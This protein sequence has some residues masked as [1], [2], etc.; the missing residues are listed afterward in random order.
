MESRSTL[1]RDANR[2]L[3]RQEYTRGE[4]VLRSKPRAL[5]IELTRHCN[6]AC[7]MCRNPGEVPAT[8]R[9]TEQLF[10]R[11]ERE[12]F[13]TADLI[14][15]RGW[16][17]S[18]IL[19]EFEDRAVRASAFGASLRV[20]TNLSFRR[21]RILDLLAELG[22][23]VGVS[24]DSADAEVLALL[25]RGA[26]L[27]LIERNLRSLADAYHRRGAAARLN[28]YVTCQKPALPTLERIV[29]LA[30]RAGIGD[31]RFAP[32]GTRLPFLSIASESRALNDAL[33]RVRV[34]AEQANIRVSM[35][36]SLIDDLFPNENGRACLHPWTWCYVAYDG[37]I[38]FCDHLI[39]ADH[40]TFASIEE[41]AFETIWNSPAW[42]ALRTEH[43][44]ERR[45]SAPYFHE[46]AWCYK[47]R[48]VDCEDIVE[49][50]AD[51]RRFTLQ[52]ACTASAVGLK[53]HP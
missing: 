34:R 25:R 15:L 49:P 41:T 21:D 32:V 47:N 8:L 29:D 52:A 53:P 31:I 36:A 45:A 28:L 20:V 14:D 17:E 1:L 12:L 33:E 24:I 43:L 9:M 3:A 6:L 44:R 13:P 18:L 30:A 26:N 11:I 48:H 22:F 23:H 7:P 5:F 19:P 46:C 42:T 4:N 39:A 50:K 51:A 10:S 40:Y 2:E 38:G 16:G 37:R 35:T 27:A